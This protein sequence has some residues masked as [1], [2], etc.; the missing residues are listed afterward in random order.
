ML[1]SRIRATPALYTGSSL[2]S[3]NTMYADVVEEDCEHEINDYEVVFHRIS[4]QRAEFVSLGLL[5]CSL[6]DITLM[7]SQL[8]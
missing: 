8:Q 3:F 4:E 5:L 2:I 7:C 6:R 1:S